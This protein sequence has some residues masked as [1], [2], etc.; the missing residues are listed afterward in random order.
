MKKINTLI[1]YLFCICVSACDEPHKPIGDDLE[2]GKSHI[3]K[4]PHIGQIDPS[5]NSKN[6]L[7]KHAMEPKL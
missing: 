6:T 3:N 4:P 5:N 1:F 2:I 7:E